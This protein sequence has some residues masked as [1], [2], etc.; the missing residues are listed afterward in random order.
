LV[1]REPVAIRSGDRPL[2]DTGGRIGADAALTLSMNGFTPR[3][4]EIY[5]TSVLAG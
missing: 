1:D 2:L 5:R 3:L 4:F